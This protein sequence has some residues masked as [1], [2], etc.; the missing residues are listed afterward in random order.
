MLQMLST[1]EALLGVRN[2]CRKWDHVSNNCQGHLKMGRCSSTEISCLALMQAND[3]GFSQM[4]I[5]LNV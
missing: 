4:E 5:Q 3:H 2:I 1:S